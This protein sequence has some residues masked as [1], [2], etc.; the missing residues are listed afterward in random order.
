MAVPDELSLRE[1]RER[2]FRESGIDAEYDV[3]WVR[4]RAGPIPLRF[5]SSR[6]RVRAAK[7]HDLHHVALGYDTSWR[8][9]A[10]IGAWEIA[11]GCGRFAWAW[12][13][14]LQAFAIGLVIAPRRTW[15]AFVR[16]RHSRS[17]Y[18]LERGFREELLAQ[19]V[20]DLRRRLGLPAARTRAGGSDGAA[21]AAWCGI[22]LADVA[23]LPL[24]V[25]AGWWLL[26]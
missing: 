8:G 21:F 15:R 23:A 9:E 1:A 19:S 11:A 17:L 25:V 4:L 26:G 13:L 16:G 2:Y 18:R 24:V 7:L 22:A 5:P 3:A 10:E 12:W 6:G 20:G 14:N